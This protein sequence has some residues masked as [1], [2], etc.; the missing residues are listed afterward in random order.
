VEVDRRFVE[1]DKRFDEV[2]RRFEA[3][4]RRFDLLDER[5]DRI[6]SEAREF[7]TEVMHRLVLI[8]ERF[9]A[10]NR[11]LVQVFAALAG[12]VIVACAA[13]IASLN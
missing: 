12:T 2:D 7:R 13:I 9:A 3:V 11:T 1:V 5:F 6:E 8:E 4:D 10:M